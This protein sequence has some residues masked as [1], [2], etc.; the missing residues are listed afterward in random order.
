VQETS[1]ARGHEAP[2]LQA[3]EIAARMDGVLRPHGGEADR[4]DAFLPSPVVQNHAANLAFLPDGTLACVWFGGTMEGMG[5]ISIYMAT[6]ADGA[7]RWSPAARL[8]D[9]PAHS[10]QN[11]ILFNAPDGQVWLFHTA[12]PGGRQDRCRIRYRRSADGGASFGP[13]REVAGFEGVFVRQPP[14]IGPA[15]EWLLAGWRCI[16]RPGRRWTGAEDWAVMLVSADQGARWLAMDVPDSLGAVHMSPVPAPSRSLSGRMPAFFRDR[17]ARTVRR[18][19]SADGGLT[20]SPPT[21]TPLPNNNSSIQATRLADGRIAMVLNPINAA[22]SPERRASLY[23]EI[24]GDAAD[25]GE[26]SG[27]GGAIWGVP[28]APL[29][30]VLSA[31]EGASFA[32]RRDLETGSGYCLTNS[33]KDGRNR[34]YSYPSIVEGPDGVLH[35]AFT[36]HRRAIKHVRLGG[37]PKPP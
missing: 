6:L 27:T 28:R 9:D 19:L 34:E 30:L 4:I 16:A 35:I 17:F 5:D 21:A 23:D 22:M 32:H 20:W 2:E 15:G 10:E 36:Y 33:S 8:T 25:G 37:V 11:P 24:D 12:Q 3:E 14:L 31:D 26:G 13:A 29:S 18:S 1:P 7:E